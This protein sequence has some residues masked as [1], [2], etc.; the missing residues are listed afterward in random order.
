V[1]VKF[2]DDGEHNYTTDG[3]HLP[4]NKVPSLYPHPVE[5]VKAIKKPSINWE[6][7][8]DEYKFLAQDVTG[9]AWLYIEEPAL[10]D[11]PWGAARCEFA[12]ADSHVSYTPGTC[13][14][15]DSLVARPKDV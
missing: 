5:V 15:K 2:S 10:D 14:W 3:K 4:S 13:D 8:R 12:S 9:S 7:V 11:G 1:A 6:H